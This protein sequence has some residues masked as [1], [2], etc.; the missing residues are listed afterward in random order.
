MHMYGTQQHPRSGAQTVIM[1]DTTTAEA[2]SEENAE[3]PTIHE[4]DSRDLRP[5]R[6]LVPFILRYPVRL[7][8]TI[9]FLLVAA[10]AQL[11]IPAALGDVVDQGFVEQNLDMVGRY[12][13]AIVV[14]ATIMAVASGARFYFISVIGERLVADL[15]Q[16]VFDHM[17]S[18]DVKFFDTARI[19]DLTSRLNTDTSTI[20]NAVGS[21][22]TLA[23]RS[24]V[25]IVG[26][27]AMMFLTNVWLTL[28]VI[29]LVP[30]IVLPVFW[31]AWRLR[32]MSRVAQNT[33]A[34]ISAMATEMLSANRTV[35]AFGQ[36]DNQKRLFAERSERSFAAE[37]RRLAARSVL[38]A[39]VIFLSTAALIALV[40]WG[41]RLVFTGAVTAGDLA[42]FMVYALLAAG[43]LSSL[44]EV[45]GSLQIV[46]GATERLFEILD[47]RS[48]L[49]L[50]KKPQALPVPALSTI[51]FE[52]VDFG[53]DRADNEVVL[54]D[55]SFSV[56][57]GE[58]VALVGPSGSGKSTVFALLQRFYDVRSGAVRVDGVDVRQ[59]DPRDLRNRF[60]YVEQESV[61]FG[62]TVADNIRFGKPDATDAEVHEAA[63]AALVEDFVGQLENGYDTLVGER[64]VM[65][66]GGQKQRIAIARALLK[67][68]PILLLD[69]ATSA[70]DAQSEHLVQTA[71]ERLMEGRT[72]LVIA[73]RLATIRHADRIL[74]LDGGRIIDEGTHDELVAKDGRYA[75]L[76]KLQ[77]RL[78]SET[79]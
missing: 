21:S 58:M 64:G 77:F 38:V 39:M 49:P 67:D 51:D 31:F 52:G 27:L 76:A 54:R 71:L 73:H 9:T 10:I 40:W 66:S 7:A 37:V 42:Q 78:A 43:S 56:R 75:E 79:A 57:K 15:R 11:A 4:D 46:A 14:I 69:E 36:E 20:R 19:G 32:D 23:L 6:R 59:T 13:W 17:L 16:T 1:T 53:Y 34:D 29:V 12:G 24:L 62:G 28:S 74:V 70:L 60:A 18:L 48:S 25:T 68:A 55:V 30:A 61:I 72:T 2:A 3:K 5:L 50:A 22:L 45:W 33:L 35:R 41:A 8:L 26:A 63:K 65:L 47:T 44:S